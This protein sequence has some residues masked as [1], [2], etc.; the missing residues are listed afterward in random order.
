MENV[1]NKDHGTEDHGGV[2]GH[3]VHIFVNEQ[4]VK[5]KA[6]MST[7]IEIK[8]AAIKQGVL[9]ERNFVLQEE[10]PNGTSRIVGDD[11]KVSIHENLRFT[12]IRPDDNS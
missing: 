1:E 11:D 2:G 4:P 6:G 3:Q 7:G 10:L 12:A 8:E 5:L 9:I